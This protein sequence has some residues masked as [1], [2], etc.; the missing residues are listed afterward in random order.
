MRLR[1]ISAFEKWMEKWGFW[2]NGRLGPNAGDA[3]VFL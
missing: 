3:S 2:E 1:P